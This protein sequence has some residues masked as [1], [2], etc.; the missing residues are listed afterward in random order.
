M[1][2]KQLEKL[3]N[4]IIENDGATI[5]PTGE[6]QSL[7]TGFM[8]SLSGYEKIYKDIKFIDLKMIKSYLRIAKSKNAFVG[9]WV[10]DKKIYI[11]LSINVIEKCEALELAKQNNQ[12][13][14]FDCLNLKEIRL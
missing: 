13:A 9:F 12:L 2:K 3:K 8:V 14:I 5:S 6:L 7:Q 4:Y 10:S 1:N 11:D